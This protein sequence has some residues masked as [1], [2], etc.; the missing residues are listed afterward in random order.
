MHQL[1]KEYNGKIRMVYKHFPLTR[2]HPYA[3]PAAL[4]AMAANDQGMFWEMTDALFEN[5]GNLSN[6]TILALAQ[7]IGLNMDL[8]KQN[9]LSPKIKEEVEKDMAQAVSLDI[10]GTPTFFINGRKLSGAKPYEAFKTV[11][12]EELGKIKIA[13]VDKETIKKEV[14]EV[15][16]E[17]LKKEAVAAR[18]E[19]AKEIK[20]EVKEEAPK[21]EAPKEVPIP[22]VK[23][24]P[25]KE[26]VAAVKEAA[27]KEAKPEIKEDV[28]KKEVTPIKKESPKTETLAGQE[29]NNWL[30]PLIV[31]ILVIVAATVTYYILRKRKGNAS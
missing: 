18:E 3:Y 20:P 4:A 5:G 30:K 21:Q 13:T 26:E 17:P 11:I 1:Y 19:P 14:P 16:R 23:E 24:E 12:E 10:K 27:P 2:I 22:I 7:K 9:L 28:A 29:K 31:I 15:K 25:K 8:F 6:E